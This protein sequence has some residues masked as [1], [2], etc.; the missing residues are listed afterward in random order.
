MRVLFATPRFPGRRAR[1]D[2]T[3][4]W[5]Q[6]RHLAPRHSITLLTC[7]APDP[8]VPACLEVQRLCERVV[9]VPRAGFAA[10]A[11]VGFALASRRPLQVALYDGWPGQ[12]A[13]AS[14]IQDG[15]FDLAHVQMARLA[16]LFEHLAP[17]PRVVDLVDALSLNMRRRARLERGPLRALAAIDAARLPR[18]ERRLCAQ[19]DAIAISAE[20]DRAAIDGAARAGI[21]PNGVDP[22]EFPFVAT[23]AAG[24][25]IVFGA[26]L[27]YFPNV[28]AALWFASEVLPRV[29]AQVPDA[30]LQLVGARPARALRRLAMHDP[31]V[32]LVGP[33]AHMHPHLAAANVAIAP[34]RAGSGQ[35]LK[36]MEAMASGAPLVASG[37]SAEGLDAVDGEHLL[38]ARD[39][40]EMAGA[41]VR[42][43]RDPALGARLAK[44][45]RAR[46][47]THHTWEQAALK[48]EGLWQQATRR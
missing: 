5:Q 24:A 39:A 9:V 21:V 29:R 17:L 6:L 18:I 23:R 25:R 34:L 12:Q 27:G 13:L 31:A 4:A 35:Q 1:G 28:D 38:V 30:R 14:V 8:A 2:Q 37:A 7:E 15:R 41:V 32:E 22:Q 42:L 46:V 47:E 10:L 48:L 19:A 11:R 33:V 36:L 43:L 16:A 45:A 20:A 26:N 3:R 44:S 40:D